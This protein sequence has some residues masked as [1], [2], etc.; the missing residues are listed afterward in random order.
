[1]LGMS[2]I[3]V[4][5]KE[6]LSDNEAALIVTESNLIQRSFADLIHSERAIVF[7]NHLDAVKKLS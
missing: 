4:I 5:V 3:L 7:K 1:M 6:W 2:E